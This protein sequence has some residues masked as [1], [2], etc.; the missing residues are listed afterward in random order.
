[1]TEA[2]ALRKEARMDARA[3]LNMD[4]RDQLLSDQFEQTWVADPEVIVQA[5]NNTLENFRLVF[6]NRFLGTVIGRM[7]ENDAIFKRILDDEQLRQALIDL[8][9]SRV[10]RKARNT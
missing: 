7:D 2:K 3:Y 8:Y 1:M 9:T 4:E 10:Y 6:G 5:R